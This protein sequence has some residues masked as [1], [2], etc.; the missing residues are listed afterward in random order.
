MMLGVGAWRLVWFNLTG[1]AKGQQVLF[2]A[3]G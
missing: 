1:D 2:A 3:C